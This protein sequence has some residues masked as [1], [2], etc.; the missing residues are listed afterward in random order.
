[1]AT[2]RDLGKS[3]VGHTTWMMALAVAG[4]VK[5]ATWLLGYVVDRGSPPPSRVVHGR[6]SGEPFYPGG[7]T[8]PRGWAGLG[9]ER[10]RRPSLPALPRLQRAPLRAKRSLAKSH[11]CAFRH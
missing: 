7:L 3:R 1:M 9:W 8:S 11:A 6:Q 10:R 2:A 4:R 5:E